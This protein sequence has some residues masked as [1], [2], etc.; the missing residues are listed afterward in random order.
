MMCSLALQ[1]KVIA[2]RPATTFL[3]TFKFISKT[4]RPK[5]VDDRYT[6]SQ[7]ELLWSQISVFGDLG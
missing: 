4:L 1:G 5:P 2:L 6:K 3:T 7:S